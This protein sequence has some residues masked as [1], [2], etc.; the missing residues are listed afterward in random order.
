MKNIKNRE[1]NDKDN[2]YKHSFVLDIEVICNEKRK[3]KGFDK[4]KYH[5][6]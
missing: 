6:N 4:I 2:R 3:S 1:L 5:M